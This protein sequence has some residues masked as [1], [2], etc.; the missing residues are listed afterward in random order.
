MER[1]IQIPITEFTI[2]CTLNDY[3]E[4]TS[5]HLQF[6]SHPLLWDSGNIQIWP[7][8]AHSLKWSQGAQ[9]KQSITTTVSL[10]HSHVTFPRAL[11]A[12]LAGWLSVD[13]L[14]G[15]SGRSAFT[16]MHGSLARETPYLDWG[17]KCLGCWDLTQEHYVMLLATDTWGLDLCT[18]V[19]RAIHFSICRDEAKPTA[20]S[21]VSQQQPMCIFL[22]N[23]SDG[24]NGAAYAHAYARP[25]AQGQ[26]GGVVQPRSWGF[27]ALVSKFRI[28]GFPKLSVHRLLFSYTRP[29]D[30]V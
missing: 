27:F 6:L 12:S 3:T 2:V 23:L 10:M 13:F 7:L 15:R 11:K 4:V 29:T 18:D 22:N 20:S 24:R 14:W 25:A 9:Q 16:C 17:S 21:L 1:S 5:A 28:K 19:T 26:R 30:K 8:Q